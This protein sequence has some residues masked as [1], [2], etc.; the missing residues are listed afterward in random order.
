MPT[1]YEYELWNGKEV[2]GVVSLVFP[3]VTSLTLFG[4]SLFKQ[5]YKKRP[6]TLVVPL[7]A[8]WID[9]RNMRLVLDVRRKSKR[10]IEIIKKCRS[11]C[12]YSPI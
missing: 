5:G 11:Y 7:F 8:R 10:Q 2:I 3:I 1:V 6:K 12:E 4:E 9:H